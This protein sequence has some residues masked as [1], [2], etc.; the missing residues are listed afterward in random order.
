[1]RHGLCM[2]AIQKVNGQLYTQDK[3]F[4]CLWTGYGS[5]W[6]A[7]RFVSRT[8]TL[9]G[10]SCSTVSCVYQEWSTT[11]RTSSQLNTTVGSIGVNMGQR[12][13]GMYLTHC[14]VH[15]PTNR[16]VPEGKR[17]GVCCILSVQHIAGENVF[18]EFQMPVWSV[19][20]CSKLTR[21]SSLAVS[22]PFHS[23]D[24]P[25]ISL[26]CQSLA[27][28]LC[29]NMVHCRLWEGDWGYR[30]HLSVCVLCVLCPTIPNALRSTWCYTK[31]D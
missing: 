22:I 31:W 23:V 30:G 11:Q 8:V 26:L 29:P 14:R 12:P 4:K 3:I 24:F 2:C 21:L 20:F 5:R 13:C 17:G 28:S 27:S 6:Q 16:G 25:T 1:M 7:H 18:K 15:A 9:L 19:S 10:F